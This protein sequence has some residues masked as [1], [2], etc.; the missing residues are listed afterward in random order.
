MKKHVLTLVLLFSA[1]LILLSVV[2]PVNPPA[3]LASPQ[4]VTIRLADGPGPPP[5]PP[6][7]PLSSQ[8]AEATML[9]SVRSWT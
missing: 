1:S 3:V 4:G 8:V 2:V 9:S 6:T 5:I 7:K